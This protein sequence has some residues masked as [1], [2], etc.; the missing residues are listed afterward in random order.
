MRLP[1]SE[2]PW[3][4]GSETADDDQPV[5]PQWLCGFQAAP[6]WCPLETPKAVPQRFS[7]EG[8]AHLPAA[9]TEE[10]EPHHGASGS[11]HPNTPVTSS[12]GQVGGGLFLHVFLSTG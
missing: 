8:R 5:L 4:K 12:P 2:P 1:G 3:W 6:Q 11:S 9:S 10:W 7:K